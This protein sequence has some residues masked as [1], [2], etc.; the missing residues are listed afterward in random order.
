M[1]Y[2]RNNTI[3]S[4]LALSL[5]KLKRESIEVWAVNNQCVD[6]LPWISAKNILLGEQFYWEKQATLKRV[7]AVI[8]SLLL[9]FLIEKLEKGDIYI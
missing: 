3:L 4:H 9:N 2:I 7:F 8:Q 1:F 5:T 6:R